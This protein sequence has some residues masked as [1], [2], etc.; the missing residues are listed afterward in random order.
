MLSSP[1]RQ[2]LLL[3]LF[4]ALTASADEKIE[5]ETWTSPKGDASILVPT[6]WKPAQLPIGTYCFVKPKS[7]TEKQTQ[8][9]SIEIVP[10]HEKDLTA[11]VARIKASNQEQFPEGFKIIED[12]KAELSGLPAWRVTWSGTKPASKGMASTEIVALVGKMRYALQFRTGPDRI[13]T[14]KPTI[15]AVLASL[16]FKLETPGGPPAK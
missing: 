12:E 8:F 4:V 14:L 5:G 3:A 13:E 7:A 6:G 2:A 10:A 11:A 15:A 9:I 1:L 16:K